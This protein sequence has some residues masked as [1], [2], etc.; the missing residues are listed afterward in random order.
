MFPNKRKERPRVASQ[1]AGLAAGLRIF[2]FFLNTEYLHYGYFTDGLETGIANIKQAQENYAQLLFSHIPA[3][4]KTILDVGC[5]SGKLAEQLIERG[6]KVDCV[7]PGAVLN[8]YAKELLGDR[9]AIFQCRFQDVPTEGKYDLILFSE[10]FQYIPTSESMPRALEM[11]NPNGH[12]MVCD[13]FRNHRH[14]EFSLGGGHHYKRWLEYKE[15]LPVKTVVEKD[16]TAE[17]APTVDIFNQFNVEVLQPVWTSLWHVTETRFPL[18]S[19][20]VRR[21]YRKKIQKAENKYFSGDR[22]AE[23]F[24]KHKKYMLYLFQATDQMR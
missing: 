13:F 15:T 4:T 5:G 14:K 6:Y 16:I 17:I 22:T 9:A 21:M 20:L 12:I 2:K 1:E 8:S 19:P 11:L 10:S 23:N 24:I 3:G 18:L 7:A